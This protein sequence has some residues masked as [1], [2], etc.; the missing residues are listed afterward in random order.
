MLRPRK[1]DNGTEYRHR[2][3]APQGRV[4]VVDERR[5]LVGC[6]PLAE[7][8]EHLEQNRPRHRRGDQ[9]HHERD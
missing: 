2:G 1:A 8:A 3:Q 7:P 9:R 6:N 5:Q 4:H